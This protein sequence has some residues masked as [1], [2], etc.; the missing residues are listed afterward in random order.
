MHAPPIL[1]DLAAVLGTAAALALLGRRLGQPP[2]L[3]Y[4]LAGLIVGPNLPVPVFADPERTRALAELGVVLVMFVVGLELRLKRLAAVLP[5]AGA[6]ALFEVACLVAAGFAVGRL[7]GWTTEGALFLGASIAIASTMVVSKVY[8]EHPPPEAVRTHVMGVLVIQDVLAILLAALLTAV[9]AGK[10]LSAAELAGV[11]GRLAG[12][13]FAVI[14]GG[15]LVVPRLIRAVARTGSAE[16]MVV[17]ASAVC[18]GLALLADH[19]GYSVALGGFFAGMLVAESGE[20][21][22]VE[23][24]V[25]PLRDLFAALFFAAVG[26][27]IDPALVW[28]HLGLSLAVLAVVLVLQFGSVT[29]AGFLSGQGL[30]RSAMAGLALGQV[31]E[32]GFILSAIGIEAGLAPPALAPVVVTV[33]VGSTFTTPLAVRH[34]E[35]IARALDRRLPARVQELASLYERWFET[36]DEAAPGDAPRPL[37]PWR[38]ALRVLVLDGL[39]ITGLL[40]AAEGAH[41]PLSA[42]LRQ[43]LGLQVPW[44]LV[45]LAVITAT[46]IAWPAVSLLRASRSLA[47]SVAD[48]VFGPA[49]DRD[50]SRQVLSVAVQLVTLLGVGVP[51][52]VVALPFDGGVAL[53]GLAVAIA[54]TAFS[55]W[56]TAEQAV[57][58]V[59]S[60]AGRFVDRLAREMAGE[61]H[62][63]PTER[64]VLGADLAE[65]LPLDTG[66]YAVGRSLTELDLRAIT[67]ATVVAL[68]GPDGAHRLPTGHEVLRAGDIVALAGTRAAVA[69]ARGLLLTGDQAN[70]TASAG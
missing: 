10:G 25:A 12:V 2:V 63:P 4:L 14:A 19:L 60:S 20:G 34:A 55:L 57:E 45:T 22:G 41:E 67:G 26:M 59:R 70:A 44:G 18:F 56:R 32:F 21:H 37:P 58:P 3:G 31:G 43:A 9:A 49:E 50:R 24:V 42:W 7:L 23:A 61:G 54:A 11:L 17:V 28:A 35:R 5:T 39:V 15:L 48:A 6:T 46:L 8:E 52:A 68:R 36:L 27:A 1:F 66:A 69:R 13:S 33:A 51:Y 65:A 40:V 29:V 62:D 16:L 38:R 30:R 47:A 53:A 64:P